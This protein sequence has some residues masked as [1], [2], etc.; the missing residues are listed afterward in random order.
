MICLFPVPGSVSFPHGN[1]L[2]TT[3][4]SPVHW[5]YIYFRNGP[6]LRGSV[7]KHSTSF[8]ASFSPKMLCDD[9]CH[10]IKLYKSGNVP[11]LTCGKINKEEAN[12][13]HAFYSQADHPEL[14]LGNQSVHW[15]IWQK[16]KSLMTTLV[17]QFFQTQLAFYEVSC[18]DPPAEG[19]AGVWDCQWNQWA[20]GMNKGAHPKYPR[21]MEEERV[22]LPTSPSFLGTSAARLAWI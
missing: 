9:L 13:A 19:L 20:I 6:S 14:T 1:V 5:T 4:L 15:L 10:R 2:G 17:L 7:W 8:T 11:C 3:S 16:I 22:C 21:E 12:T 18:S